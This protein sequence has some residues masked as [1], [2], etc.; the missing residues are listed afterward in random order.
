MGLNQTSLNR[1]KGVHPKLISVVNRA[2]EICSV[3]LLVAEGVR[4]LE[5]Q[6]EYFTQG[7]SQTLNSR[8]LT[9]H[10]VDMYALLNNQLDF[11]DASVLKVADAMIKAARE[12]NVNMTWG[13]A[14]KQNILGNTKTAYQLREDYKAMRK[15]LNAKPFLDNPH[16]E[17]DPNV[18]KF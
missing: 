12:L 14:W 16:F 3:P 18:Y 7:K 4:T 9:G 1:L 13:S 2:V 17:I 15:S 11:N 10:A 5:K 6:K 8:H